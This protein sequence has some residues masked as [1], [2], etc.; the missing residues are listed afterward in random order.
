[1]KI[2]IED[3]CPWSVKHPK[4]MTPEEAGRRYMAFIEGHREKWDCG[5]TPE[6]AVKALHQT[7]SESVGLP[8]DEQQVLRTRS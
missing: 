2:V 6:A 1:M 5:K 8:V 7:W 4:A 3:R